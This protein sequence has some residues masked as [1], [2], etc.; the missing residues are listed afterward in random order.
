MFRVVTVQAVMRHLHLPVVV[1]LPDF[2]D[3]PFPLAVDAVPV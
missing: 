2:D 1:V 3:H